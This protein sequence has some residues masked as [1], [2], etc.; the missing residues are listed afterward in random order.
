[1]ADAAVG[2]GA[3]I[4]RYFSIVSMVPSLFLVVWSTAL[5]ASDA[6][7]SEPNLSRMVPRLADIGFASITWLLLATI[8]VALFLHPLQLAMTRFLE[9]YWGSSPM[10][11]KLLSM[12]IT[13]YRKQRRSLHTQERELSN[14]LKRRL[15]I[16]LAEQY[17]LDLL[18][19]EPNIVHPENLSK[20]DR[21]EAE[22]GMFGSDR[23][24]E[25]SGLKAALESIR[26]EKSRYPEIDR[27]MPTRLGNALRQAE[28]SVGRQYGLSAIRTAPYLALISP[29][30]DRSY[31]NDTRQQLDTSVRLCVVALLATIETVACLFTDGFWLLL[32]L[33]PY[34]LAYLA[35][36]GAIAAADTYMAVV[37]TVLDLNRFKLY[38]SLHVRLPTSTLQERKANGALM[39]LLGGS[40]EVNVRYKH[41]STGTPPTPPGSP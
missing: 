5:V 2:L 25:L 41:P 34:L 10:A 22:L 30:L 38:E 13:H 33:G 32:A 40:D 37:R 27:M 4:G 14:I 29:E 28:D 16:F 35:Y 15:K 39:D 31:L 11:V 17:F 1:M 20:E 9:G 36:R 8:I 6:W 23:A 21:K 26:Q 19:E 3:R 18:D 12:R 7:Q 24:H